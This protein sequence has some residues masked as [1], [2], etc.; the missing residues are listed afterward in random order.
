[1]CVFV[2]I[3]GS[4]QAYPSDVP[5]L[6]TSGVSSGGRVDLKE[7]LLGSAE[8]LRQWT[9]K[10]LW[11]HKFSIRYVYSNVSLSKVVFPLTRCVCDPNPIKNREHRNKEG[12]YPLTR[13]VSDPNPIIRPVFFYRIGERIFWK[14]GRKMVSVSVSVQ[15]LASFHD[16]LQNDVI[17]I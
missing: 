7:K 14:I 8:C 4:P 9:S 16:V 10:W 3:L 11:G 17:L 5:H 6:Q 2:L 12:V 13:C 1:M 15:R